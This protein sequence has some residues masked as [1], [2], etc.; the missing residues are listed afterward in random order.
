MKFLLIIFLFL[1]SQTS[2][3]QDSIIDKIE[4]KYQK[5]QPIINNQI[6]FSEQ[7]YNYA[8]GINFEF[9]KWYTTEIE[10]DTLILAE[11]LSIVKNQELGLLLFID[12]YSYSGD[13]F[14]YSEHYY[15]KDKRLYF[16]LWK[17]NTFH[18]E[19]PVTVERKL[20]FNKEGKKIKELET[21]YK[22]NTNDE[23]DIPYMQHDVYYDIIF[24]KSEYL[25]TI[26]R[27]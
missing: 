6:S 14:I 4:S 21:V 18:A 16:V 3:S 26:K 2:F 17:M 10:N 13:W 11:V 9:N 19:E 24:N 8:W 5:W 1:A 15:D 25:K 7:Y 12:E 27:E 23:I 20:Y 22:M